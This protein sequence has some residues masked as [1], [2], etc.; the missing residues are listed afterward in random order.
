MDKQNEESLDAEYK[1]YL[2]IMRPYLGQILDQNV[3]EICNDWIQKLCQSESNEKVLRNKYIFTLCYQLARGTLEEPFVSKPNFDE[4]PPLPSNTN[5]DESSTEMEYILVDL[6]NTKTLLNNEE[7]SVSVTGIL[8]KNSNMTISYNKSQPLRYN[9]MPESNL[10]LNDRQ[11]NSEENISVNLGNTFQNMYHQARIKNLIY[12]MRN[13]KQQNV[14]LREELIHLKE[15]SIM[16][17]EY[18]DSYKDILKIDAATSTCI[19]SVECLM[20][21]KS[22]KCKLED[23]QASRNILMENLSALK[24]TLDDYDDMKKFE[25]E[26]IQAKHKLQIMEIETNIKQELKHKYEQKLAETKN[27]YEESLNKQIDEM[28]QIIESKNEIIN[29]KNDEIARLNSNIEE[30]KNNLTQISTT[31]KTDLEKYISTCKKSKNKYCRAYEEK[32][33][34]LK[35]EKQLAE[36]FMQLQLMKQRAQITKDITDEYQTELTT[37]LEK[38]ENKYKDIIA[39]VQATAVQ[40]RFLDQMTLGSLIQTICGIRKENNSNISNKQEQN[41]LI[42]DPNEVK[43]NKVVFPGAVQENVVGSVIVGKDSSELTKYYTDNEKIIKLIEKSRIPQR[44]LGHP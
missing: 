5:R 13:L 40:R 43:K 44:D 31:Q 10:Q 29:T 32:I 20:S 7:S 8:S 24:N 6:E 16:R 12:K 34:N 23:V 37:A 36:C 30:L 41:H 26:E 22:L 18:D 15:N 42:H 3:I 39:S 25:I 1:H 19:P 14:D 11:S 27:Q 38:L 28:K 2:E 35:K 4:L 33:Y 17:E 9:N 21:V